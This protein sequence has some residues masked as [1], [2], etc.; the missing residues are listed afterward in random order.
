[1]HAN[2]WKG[3][4]GTW[5]NQTSE[6]PRIVISQQGNS[7][8]IK[9]WGKCPSGTCELEKVEAQ[10]FS[11]ASGEAKP[12]LVAAFRNRENRKL[13]VRLK[14]H[15]GELLAQI[16]GIEEKASS[17]WMLIR[18]RREVSKELK[19][20]KPEAKKAGLQ[21]TG[22]IMGKATGPAKTTASVFH[23]SLY[24][25]D[26]D[27]IS[28]QAFGR[29]RTYRFSNLADGMYYIVVAS[30]GMPHIQPFPSQ[31]QLIIKDGQAVVQDVSLE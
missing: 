3:F 31:K 19:A 10:S 29:D 1:M 6:I 17:A 20:K 9:A 23:L 12:V 18:Y 21:F 26:G 28:T 24:D 22:A 8:Y 13:Q 30:R 2:S 4:L 5:V 15:S 11:K 16:E 7:T 25:A 27:M 14:Q